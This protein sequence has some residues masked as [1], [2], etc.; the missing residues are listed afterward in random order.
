MKG[1]HNLEFGPASRATVERF[2]LSRR[3]VLVGTGALAA[4]GAAGVV[5]RAWSAHGWPRFADGQPRLRMPFPAGTVVLCEQ[6]NASLSGTHTRDRIQNTFAL[7]F[8]NSVLDTVVVVAAAPGVVSFV[9]AGAGPDDPNAG[10]QYGNQVRIDHGGGYETFYAHLD[11]VSAVQGQTVRAGEPLGTMGRTGLAGGRHL[12]LS[13]HH[14]SRE[15]AG[16]GEGESLP[17]D[18]LLTRDVTTTLRTR[19]RWTSGQQMVADPSVPW[20]GHLYASENAP[21]SSI[22]DGDHPDLSPLLERNQNDL[23]TTLQDRSALAD[24]ARQYESL[25]PEASAQIVDPALERDPGSPVANYF[26]AVA[27]LMPRGKDT[28]ARVRLEGAMRDV[29]VPRR[30]EPWLIPYAQAHLGILAARSGDLKGAEALF[31]QA[32]RA[33]PGLASVVAPYRDSP[34][35]EAR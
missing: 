10:A 13:V 3:R 7:D 15:D 28:E 20:R 14:V 19:F 17:I 18:G 26:E 1:D 25:G 31:D 8:S 23:R 9:L 2:K 30:Y 32:V 34:T 12:H 24:L 35:L 29:F 6:G 16:A 22:D 11:S 5:L 33:I 21:G 4:L 27:V